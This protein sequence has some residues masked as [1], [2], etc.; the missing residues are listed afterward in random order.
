MQCATHPDVETE[1][2]CSRCG[3]AICPR[4]LV[5][6][7]VGARCSTCANVRR[8][9][10]YKMSSDVLLRGA[11]AAIGAGVVIG[12]VWAL[13]N[14]ITA[15]FY[16]ILAGLAFGYAIG[17]LVSIGTN[18]RAGP[19]LQAAAVGGVVLAYVVRTA[20]LLAIGGWGFGDLRVDLV[21]LIV[22]TLASF[23]AAGRLR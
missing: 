3:K 15:F 12:I 4:C 18:R 13:F 20:L 7:P 16:G 22:V 21:G 14:P 19:P 17:E 9:P 6:T 8:I 23:I 5:H 1:L 10:T 2:T 11:G